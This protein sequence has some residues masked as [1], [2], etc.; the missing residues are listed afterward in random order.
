M[1][2]KISQQLQQSTWKKLGVIYGVSVTMEL[3]WS[4]YKEG[5]DALQQFRKG[6]YHNNWSCDTEFDAVVDGI[7]QGA[8]PERYKRHSLGE[9]FFAASLFPVRLPL[10]IFSGMIIAT[11]PADRKQFECP[12]AAVAGKNNI[13]L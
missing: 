8:H 11:H 4:S 2:A 12:P 9:R 5:V 6:K 3:T 13:N 7:T 1:F 10:R